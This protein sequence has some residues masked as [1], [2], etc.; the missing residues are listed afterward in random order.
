MNGTSQDKTSMLLIVK[1]KEA[2][3]ILLLSFQITELF[4]QH[5]QS[6]QELWSYLSRRRGNLLLC[7]LQVAP[8]SAE[9]LPILRAVVWKGKELNRRLQRQCQQLLHPEGSPLT[10]IGLTL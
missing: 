5:R 10:P 6:Q 7:T 3:C 1:E 8:L 2:A 9:Q 4:Y